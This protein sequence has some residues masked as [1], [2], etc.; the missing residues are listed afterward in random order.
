MMKS[1]ININDKKKYKK[2]E[3]I[4]V[5]KWSNIYLTKIGNYLIRILNIN[6]FIWKSPLIKDSHFNQRR[7]NMAYQILTV[8]YYYSNY[9]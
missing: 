4:F 8:Y 5:D 7:E 9:N 6:G 2:S 1:K 3:L